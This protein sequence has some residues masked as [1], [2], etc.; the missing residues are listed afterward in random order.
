LHFRKSS[1][2][3]RRQAGGRVEWNK[4]RGKLGVVVHSCNPSTWEAEA[5]GWGIQGQPGLHSETLLERERQT[6]RQSEV[7]ALI[8]AWNEECPSE[9]WR[10]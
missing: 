9:G 8:K 1:S 2:A 4:R 7:I 3:S 6:D 5:G 10:G